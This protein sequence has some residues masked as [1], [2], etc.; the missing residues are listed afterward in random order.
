M[1]KSAVLYGELKQ[2]ELA[3][4]ILERCVKMYPRQAPQ[5][6]L[7]AGESPD[8]LFDMTHYALGRQ[9]AALGDEVRLVQCW[10]PYLDGLRDS[11][12]RVS[13]LKLTG[14]HAGQAG[15]YGPAV[16][17][18]ATLLDEYGTNPTDNAGQPIPIP[19]EERLRRGQS[20]NGIRLPP[21]PDLDR[22]EIRYA[23]GFL[24]WQQREWAQCVK[25]LKPVLDDPSLA[26]SKNRGKALHMLGQS[27]YH[28]SDF[29]AGL[30]A[31]HTLL[32]DCP[33]FEAIQEAYCQAARGYAETKQ[34]AELDL[35]YRR[36]VGEWP[37]SP[38]R[39]RMDLYAALALIGQGE[40][41]K[42]LANLKS[43]AER[44]TFEDVQADACCW[45]A[46]TLLAAQ[47][48]DRAAAMQ[49]FER[50]L[51]IY[52]RQATCLEA[53]ELAIALGRWPQARDLLDRTIRE[54]PQGEERT[55]QAAR[56]LMPDVLKEL[57]KPK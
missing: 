13:A 43:L 33:Q 12:F 3:A 32:Q 16:T 31:L 19:Q 46:R 11:K 22:G 20:W 17:A 24:Y 54:F 28:L 14:Y 39:P 40:S 50:S 38:E 2:H 37:D 52:P 4:A 34:W 18:Y 35:V 57:A 45:L 23:L 44:T 51:I 55:V 25:T 56:K 6:D 15:D 9:Y 21:P 30:Q 7:A 36:F 8:P 42:G 5:Q 49:Y 29:P 53:A 48:P 47:P 41:A 26:G 1:L 27:H 10:R